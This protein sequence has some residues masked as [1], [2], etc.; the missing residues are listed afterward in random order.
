MPIGL[1]LFKL[2]TP[3]LL[4]PLLGVHRWRLHRWA[5]GSCR[6]P[7]VIQMKTGS[8]FFIAAMSTLLCGAGG[9]L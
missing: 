6:P 8:P 7:F 3:P 2:L 1:K 9:H 4:F 5:G